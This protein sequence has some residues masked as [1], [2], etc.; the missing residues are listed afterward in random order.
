[1][2]SFKEEQHNSDVTLLKSLVVATAMIPQ[3]KV[4]TVV[5]VSPVSQLKYH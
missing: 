5:N 1:V 2:A 4:K 3:M